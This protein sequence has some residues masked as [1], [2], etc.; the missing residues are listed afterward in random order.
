MSTE[1]QITANRLNA[2]K[3]TGPTTPEGKAAVSQNALKHGLT[4]E[5]DLISSESLPEFEAF[6][7]ATIREYAPLTAVELMLAQRVVSLSWR[8]R[9]IGLIQNQ[10]LEVLNKKNSSKSFEKLYQSILPEKNDPSDED[11]ALA[12]GRLA[13][14]DFTHHKI[15]DRLLMY[16][17]RTEHSL[18]KTI[19]QLHYIQTH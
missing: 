6:R 13:I 7:D 2:E 8:L 15:L 19:K 9:R 16:E 18:L 1:A 5:N 3:S 10:A 12:L 11:P 4:S 14:K 17:R